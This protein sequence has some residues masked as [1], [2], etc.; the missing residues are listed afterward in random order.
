[1][2]KLEQSII[3]QLKKGVDGKEVDEKGYL[4]SECAE[5]NLL[6]GLEEDWLKI[7]KSFLKGSGNELKKDS[8]GR[9]KF[10]ALHSSSALCVNA[11]APFCLRKDVDR[12][13]DNQRIVKANFEKEMKI[14][15]GGTPPTL[16]FFIETDDDIIG[17]E[18]KFTE[19]LDAKSNGKY[20]KNSKLKEE[21]VFSDKFFEQ[22]VRPFMP[23]FI[24]LNVNQLVKHIMGLMNNN[25][26][27]KE[28]TLF[29]IYWTPKSWAEGSAYD[30]IYKQHK[31]EI[32]E[33]SEVIDAYAEESKKPLS[34]KAMSYNE[35]WERMKEQYPENE[36]LDEHIKAFKKR[37]DFDL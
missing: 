26:D 8:N 29:Y 9:A 10:C 35:F 27:N 15:M 1:M 6:D 37:Y 5:D 24:Y 33:F 17:I 7:K 32:A 18:S 23:P 12:F 14:G 30:K 31:K 28:I 16:D 22:V 11:F 25:P 19:Y 4:V 20:Y 36:V 3:E 13:L 21:G 34:F 2:S